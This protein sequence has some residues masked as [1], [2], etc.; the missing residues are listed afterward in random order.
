MQVLPVIERIVGV[1]SRLLCHSWSTSCT[2]Y[3]EK[4]VLNNLDL[5]KSH[6]LILLGDIHLLFHKVQEPV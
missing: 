4:S 3:Q 6:T 5:E 1:S 2:H